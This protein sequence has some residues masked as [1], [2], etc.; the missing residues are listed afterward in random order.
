MRAVRF[1]AAAV[2]LAGIGLAG[3]SKQP[4]E[5]A[6]A[7]SAAAPDAPAG[8]AV[9]NGRLVLPAVSG[10]PAA[11]YFDVANTGTADAA[12]AGVSVD[13][14]K[15]A[16]LHM[17]MQS[18]GVSSMM[19]MSSIPVPKGQTVRFAPGGNHVMATG[20]DPSLKGGDTTEVTLTFA[21]GDKASFP[22]KIEAVGTE[23]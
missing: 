2:I 6:A 5:Q 23:P 22:A 17:T 16:M 4:G 3:C 18:G 9:T 21:T 15:S 20:L 14:A 12:I 11:V 8:I 7:S 19:E 10:N 1:T 13:G